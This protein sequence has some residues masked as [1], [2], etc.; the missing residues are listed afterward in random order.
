[1]KGP[2]KELTW[3]TLG[4]NK[5][6]SISLEGAFGRLLNAKLPWEPVGGG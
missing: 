4:L 2:H 6:D 1:M 5:I 3:E